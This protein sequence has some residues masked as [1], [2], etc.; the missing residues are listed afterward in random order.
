MQ[1]KIPQGHPFQTLMWIEAVAAAMSLVSDVYLMWSSRFAAM[2][3]PLPDICFAVLSLIAVAAVFAI[4][5]RPNRRFVLVALAVAT[6]AALGGLAPYGITPI[7][8]SAILAARL[9]F[10]LGTPGAAIAWAT[11]C[12]AIFLR[13]LSQTRSFAIPSSLP[14]IGYTVATYAILLGLLFGMIAVIAAYAA[15]SAASAAAEERARIALDLHDAIGHTLTTL[16]VHLENA[17]RYR[18]S[19]SAKAD[20]YVERAADMARE[21]LG[22]VR[23]TVAVLHDDRRPAEASLASMA[24]RVIR[25][26]AS[27]H[28][29]AVEHTI[30]LDSEPSARV[31]IALFRVLQE[32]LTNIGRHAR[33]RRVRVSLSTDAARVTM[34]IEDDGCGFDGQ[35]SEGHGLAFMRL[36]MESVGGTLVVTSREGGGTLVE[37]RAPLE[38]SV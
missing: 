31:S 36:R 23:E 14:I 3:N 30:E 37:A 10:A 9:T 18:A 24:D 28:D 2:V 16:G 25:D 19:D 26:F 34:T 17:R 22:D 12:A 27:T 8:L 6:V 1:S 38:T 5:H 7:V 33:A 20:G 29:L 15:Q 32:A 4:P 13:V 35:S 11:G 21:V